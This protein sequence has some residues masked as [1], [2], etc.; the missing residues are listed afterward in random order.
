VRILIDTNVIMDVLAN[1]PEFF[2]HSSQVFAH[3]EK[4]M[5]QGIIGATT[6]TTLS[7][8]LAKK[9]GQRA[10]LVS[11]EKLLSLTEV[12]PVNEAVLP[13]A[14]AAG[15]KDFEDSVLIASAELVGADGIVT[16]DVHGFTKSSL[17]VYAPV[18]LLTALRF[19]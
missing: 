10:S 3:V 6:V 18:E 13:A 15:G 16:R 1:R 11:I 14:L 5:I 7:Y 4:G 2:H 8:L 12:A 17:P 19:S 9:L